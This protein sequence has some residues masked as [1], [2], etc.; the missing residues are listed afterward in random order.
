MRVTWPNAMPAA[1]LTTALNDFAWSLDAQ[2]DAQASAPYRRHLVR[3]LGARVLA[4][5]ME[6]PR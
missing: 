1:D 2:G 6:S 4:D 3:R 5:V